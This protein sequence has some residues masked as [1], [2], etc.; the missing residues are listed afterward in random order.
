MRATEQ[1][2]RRLLHRI[3]LKSISLVSLHNISGA[4]AELGR[5]V[6]TLDSTYSLDFLPCC[7]ADPRAIRLISV[8][9]LPPLD[10][11]TFSDS[12]TAGFSGI[13]S[14]L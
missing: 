6:K 11:D 14:I 12:G 7:L 1:T 9:D 5:F 13:R 10:A 8:G 2:D 3:L 4:I